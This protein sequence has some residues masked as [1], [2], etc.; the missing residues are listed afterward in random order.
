MQCEEEKISMQG[1]K[2]SFLWSTELYSSTL[3]KQVLNR[4]FKQAASSLEKEG[5]FS[6]ISQPILLISRLEMLS[7][8]YMTWIVGQY[9]FHEYFLVY[10]LCST[11]SIQ[12]LP[13]WTVVLQGGCCSDRKGKGSDPQKHFSMGNLESCKVITHIGN[14]LWRR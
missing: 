14:Y 8:N 10:D 5:S 4:T 2:L 11:L 9:I 12:E 1:I 13:S 3:L 7:R 6:G